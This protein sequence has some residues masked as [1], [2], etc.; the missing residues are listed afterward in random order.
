[1]Y[2]NKLKVDVQVLSEILDSELYQMPLNRPILKPGGEINSFHEEALNCF[3]DNL[4]LVL[5]HQLIMR[6]LKLKL[7]RIETRELRAPSRW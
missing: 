5:K 2:I 7:N 6:K 1:M 4:P 3:G